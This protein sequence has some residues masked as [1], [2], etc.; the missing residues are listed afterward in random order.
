MYTYIYKHVYTYI[1]IDIFTSMKDKSALKYPHNFHFFV[2][3]TPRR[4]T[5]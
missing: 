3:N 1:Y 4:S 5:R 2:D